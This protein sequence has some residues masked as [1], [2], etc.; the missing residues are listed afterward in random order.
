MVTFRY[1]DSKTGQREI[2]TVGGVEF[3]R[4]ILQH[5]LPKGFRRARNY[6]FLHPNS[7][8][9]IALLQLKFL[10][11][12]K[13]YVPTPRPVLRCACCGGP[14]TV[15]ARRIKTPQ[16]TKTCVDP[17]RDATVSQERGM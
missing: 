16:A 17:V 13:P 11:V 5:T 3:L 1:R 15:V 2:R 6:G 10:M 12:F 14:K 8:R 9:T 7:K 4:L